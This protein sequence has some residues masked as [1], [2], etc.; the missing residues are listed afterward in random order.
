MIEQA[1]YGSQDV[2][3]YRFLARSAGFRDDWLPTA[4]R[5]C[6]GFG[7]RPAGV[8]CPAC[9]F[10]RP[11]GKQHVAVVQVADRG[12]DDAGRPGA[13][14]FYLLVLPVAA[15]TNLG[16]DPFVVA[17]R[18]PPPWDARGEVPVLLWPEE[19]LPPRTVE[20]VQQV[21]QRPDGPALLGAAQVLVD[22]GRVVF[23]RPVPDTSLMRSLWALLP[24]TTRG[25]LWPAGF[26]FG[27]ALGFDALVV[28]RAAG[29]EYDRY[30]TEEQAADYPAGRYEHNLQVAAEAGD[31]PSLDALFARRSGSDTLR[32]GLILVIFLSL[33]ALLVTWLIPERKPAAEPKPAAPRTTPGRDALP[34]LPPFKT[35]SEPERKELT[36]KL[37]DLAGKLGLA[38]PLPES[39]EG[40]LEV[41]DQ[42]LARRRPPP[43]PWPV[44]AFRPLEWQ[45]RV[46]LWKQ[47]VDGYDKAGL[48]PGEMID[49]LAKKVLAAKPAEATP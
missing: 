6:T 45:V 43:D 40:L 29:K 23:E 12:T 3:G 8:A 35:P 24:T 44:S 17:D 47:G 2:G 22:G 14:G 26:A 10:A 11:L 21:L 34:V 15:Y 9:L 46:L 4:E 20:Q 25:R 37:H 48:T 31:Q 39:A 19:P 32:L 27:N 28:P 49:R 36:Q 7:E 16:G 5:L 41:I 1:L 13:L 30:V 42:H 33:A 38:P 18:F